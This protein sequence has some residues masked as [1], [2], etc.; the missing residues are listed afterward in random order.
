MPYLQAVGLS[1]ERSLDC[2][3]LGC[4]I[5][6]TGLP[7]AHICLF[8]I[9]ASLDRDRMGVGRATFISGHDLR[10]SLRKKGC[11]TAES[12]GDF[13]L[14]GQGSP[15]DKTL[16]GRGQETPAEWHRQE[17]PS[18]WRMGASAQALAECYLLK[19]L[20]RGQRPARPETE[21]QVPAEPRD[22]ETHLRPR[23]LENVFFLLSDLIGG[24]AGLGSE[25]EQLSGLQAHSGVLWGP[26]CCSKA[27]CH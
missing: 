12:H 5:A 26:Q 22:S 7:P 18:G 23:T 27:W 3:K 21:R 20:S 25:L 19:A 2:Y 6:C 13:S 11:V 16:P 17:M 10:H 8:S 15:E 4:T 24:S 9:H 1:P 14:G